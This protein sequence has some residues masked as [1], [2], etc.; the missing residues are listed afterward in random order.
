M[1]LMQIQLI[2]ENKCPYITEIYTPPSN[3]IFQF[4]LQVAL[5]LEFMILRH[6]MYIIIITV[7]Q[8]LDLI[9]TFWLSW[10]LQQS[11]PVQ[12]T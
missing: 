7:T 5:A 9:V 3:I 11:Y 4:L 2:L 8:Y 1:Q 10:F 12:L 6:Q